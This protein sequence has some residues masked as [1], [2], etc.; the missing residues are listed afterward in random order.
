MRGII[1]SLD[2]KFYIQSFHSG[3][4]PSDLYGTSIVNNSQLIFNKDPLTKALIEGNFYIADELNISPIST[5]LSITPILDFIFDTRLFIPGI[6]P[7]DKELR[8]SST[9]FLIIC[10]NNVDIIGRSKLPLSLMRKIRKLNYP[11][12]EA[13]DIEK[14]AMI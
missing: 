1:E 5:I 4:E 13:N 8:I 3:S 10:Q 6:I 12:L 2:E 9:F 14:I 7:Y 11:K